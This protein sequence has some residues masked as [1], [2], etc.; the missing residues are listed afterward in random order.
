MR[1]NAIGYAHSA[2]DGCANMRQILDLLMM[3]VEAAALEG[4]N[5]LESG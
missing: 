1:L 5:S 4:K 3:R 2:N